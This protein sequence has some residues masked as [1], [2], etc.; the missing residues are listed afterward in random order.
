MSGLP[1]GL[2]LPAGDALPQKDGSLGRAAVQV[3]R[4][5]NDVLKVKNLISVFDEFLFLIN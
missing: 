3:R 2:L 5:W 1:E 4:V